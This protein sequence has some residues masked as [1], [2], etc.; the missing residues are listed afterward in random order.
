MMQPTLQM[1]EAFSK[2]RI[3][4]MFRDSPILAGKLSD[5]KSRDSGNTLLH[6]KFPG[7]HIT[8]CGANSP[9]SL[10]MR[11]IRVVLKDDKDRFPTSAGGEGDPGALADKRTTTFHNRKIIEASTPTTEGSSQI[12]AAYE[13][14]DQRRFYVPCPH[15]G[16]FQPLSWSGIKW[17]K[18]ADNHWNDSPPW[19]ECD[20]CQ[21]AIQ[22]ED[23][24]RVLRGSRWTAESFS[25][26]IAGFHI[27]ELC[28]TWRTWQNIVSDFHA[29]KRDTELLRVWTNTTLG[30]TFREVGEG[31]DPGPLMARREVYPAQVPAGALVLCAG[32][33]VQD[34]RLEVTVNGYGH[35]DEN[36]KITKRVIW[37][38]PG[39]KAVWSDLDDL[40]MRET[41]D[42]ESG[43]TLGIAG[44]CIDSGGHHTQRVYEYCRT[45]A[46]K[47]IF[48]IKGMPGFGRPVVSAPSGKRHGRERRPVDLFL[49]GVDEIKARIYARLKNDEPGPGY[50]HFPRTDEFDE[51]YF[52]QLTAEEIKTKMVM[53]V[54]KREWRL[55]SGRRNEALDCDV[56]SYAALILIK[57]N[58]EALEKRL[59]ESAA[60][61][62]PS[63][64]EGPKSSRRPGR[65]RGGFVNS[66]KG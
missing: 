59:G 6:K 50:V 60:G 30:E 2:D 17:A 61:G 65:A 22:E 23:K 26:G 66:W 32:V 40:L 52:D 9:Q 16:V 63:A 38:D 31:M 21:G 53:G 12:A 34:D 43:S 55:P 27:N 7:G 3:A 57:P 33:D 56:Y 51:A 36:W 8:L 5:P 42:H 10:A 54:S 62:E 47:R 29:A 18:G 44:T 37:G 13:E 41:F 11:P 45:R 19:Y 46:G 39:G 14:S 20:S 24:A 48:A 58:L 64:T 15:C 1:A 49:L 4:P 25:D 28:S 35:G